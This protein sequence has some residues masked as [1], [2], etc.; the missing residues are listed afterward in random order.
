M[1][2]TVLKQIQINYDIP[3]D[4]I[5]LI[6]NELNR[7]HQC[8]III[9]DEIKRLI[10]EKPRQLCG[11]KYFMIEAIK[12]EKHYF[13]NPNGIFEVSYDTISL[14]KQERE[15]YIYI[16]TNNDYYLDEVKEKYRT[17]KEYKQYMLEIDFNPNGFFK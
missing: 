9:Q 6:Y 11:I 1:Y 16:M 13:R 17:Y 12:G 15:D 14:R 5:Q 3:K 7:K 4:I 10:A 2:E 8:A